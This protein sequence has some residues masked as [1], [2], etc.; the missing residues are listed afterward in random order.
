MP[1]EVWLSRA[2]RLA[3]LSHSKLPFPRDLVAFVE[4][5]LCN[6]GKLRHSKV[7]IPHKIP[8]IVLAQHWEGAGYLDVGGFWGF[9][10]VKRSP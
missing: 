7:S 8:V 3:L 9:L 2:G 10:F 5:N 1:G 6:Y 4:Q